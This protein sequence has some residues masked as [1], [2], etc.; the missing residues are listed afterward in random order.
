MD[1]ALIYECPL[2]K[3]QMFDG[4]NINYETE[5]YRELVDSDSSASAFYKI[6][7]SEQTVRLSF[8][9]ISKYRDAVFADVGAGAGSFLDLVKGFSKQTIAIEPAQ[10]Y[11]HA[12]SAK[13][14]TVFSYTQDA[15]KDHRA[16]AEIVTCFSVIEHIDEPVMFMNELVSLCKPGG[17]VIISTPNS[18]D[19]LINFL[20]ST[21]KPFF[22]RV[23]H[24]WY[25]SGDA[26][27][28]LAEKSGLKNVAIKY[29]QRFN[30]TNA[31]Q[32]IKEGKPTGNSDALF[33]ESLESSYQQEVEKTGKADYIYMIAQ[34]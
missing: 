14:H 30:L 15:L 13:G 27:K 2:C 34:K 12:L 20:P 28:Q 21:Y 17:T 4:L 31:L 32:W 29:K 1:N 33:S 3:T 22:Y 11:H 9:D 6:H 10:Q 26:L 18:E 24:K 16:Q 23:V 8:F 19:W 7:D 5:E 25:F